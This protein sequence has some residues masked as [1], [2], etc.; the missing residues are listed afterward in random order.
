MSP[1]GAGN[2]CLGLREGVGPIKADSPKISILGCIVVFSTK[3]SSE[4]A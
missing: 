3:D 2:E 4:I 1:L